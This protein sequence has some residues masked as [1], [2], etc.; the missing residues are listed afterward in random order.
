MAHSL[1][2]ESVT[3]ETS[4]VELAAKMLDHQHDCA[5][6]TGDARPF[7]VRGGQSFR[8]DLKLA[9]LEL[10]D[11]ARRPVT[12]PERHDVGLIARCCGCRDDRRC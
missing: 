1:Y 10:D 7:E 2:V 6:E 3:A 11:L 12:I 4:I 9:M 5:R 8:L